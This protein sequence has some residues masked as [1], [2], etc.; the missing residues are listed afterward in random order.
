MVALLVSGSC[1]FGSPS[2][3][4]D[5]VIEAGITGTPAAGKHTFQEL[6]TVSLNYVP[7]DPL[8]TVEVVLNGT[9]RFEGTGSFIMY[10]DG[11]N[12]K[13]SLMDVRGAYKVTLSYTDPSVTAPAP[14][15]ITLTGANRL[16]GAFTDDRL[17][18][19]TWTANANLL[20]LAYWDWDF[21][22]LS[23]SVFNFGTSAG[24]FTGG[25]YIGTWTA[26]KQ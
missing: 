25:G 9:L 11:Y 5:V 22:I 1:K 13:A 15:I 23:A 14:F 10:G 24:T 19:G 8:E 17:L 2:Y 18:H 4:L 6:T 20:T 7:V 3:S 12:L 26:V 16:S 21:Y